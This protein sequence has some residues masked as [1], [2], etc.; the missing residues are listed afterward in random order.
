MLKKGLFTRIKNCTFEGNNYVGNF[1]HV[2]GCQVGKMTYIGSYCSLL[3]T[4]I[5]QY[6][7]IASDVKVIAGEHPAHQWVSTHPA[8]YSPHNACGKSFSN[9]K[10]FD[11][12][13]FADEEKKFFVQIGNDVWL[14]A[15]V[16][17]VNGVS[18]GD[19]AIVA[20][21][22]VVTKNVPPYHIVGGVP[23][24]KI[25]QRFEDTDIDFLLE[26]PFWM[27]DEPWISEH[28]E[29]FCSIE[30]YKKC[31]EDPAGSR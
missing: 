19:G 9:E 30:E 1:S 20:A 14:G 24:K 28:A 26:H 21:G 11:E 10:R 3:Y 16:R 13:K 5:G 23:A 2:H 25:G 12:W 22:A 29:A 17:I 31:F 7:S 8:F 6:C 18:I 4:K 15:G 27:Q